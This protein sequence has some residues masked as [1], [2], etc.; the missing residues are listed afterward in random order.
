[1]KYGVKVVLRAGNEMLIRGNNMN[2]REIHKFNLIILKTMS[3]M[4]VYLF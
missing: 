1:M 4:R 3:M 2:P